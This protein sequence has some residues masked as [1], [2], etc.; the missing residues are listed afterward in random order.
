LLPR[1]PGIVAPFSTSH[2]RDKGDRDKERNGKK[3]KKRKTHDLR[4]RISNEVTVASLA[5]YFQ[6]FGRLLAVNLS[7]AAT[8]SHAVVS[9]SDAGALARAISSSLS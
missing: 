2:E 8:D 3:Q 4:V 1:P 9:F 6:Q 7:G 5:C